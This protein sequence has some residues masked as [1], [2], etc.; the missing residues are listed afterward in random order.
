MEVP[1]LGVEWEQQ[2]PTYTTAT[3]TRDLSASVTYTTAHSNAGS[4]T[5]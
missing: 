3:A 4:L 1:G 2:L 5:R